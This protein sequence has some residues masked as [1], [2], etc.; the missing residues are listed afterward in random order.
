VT[1]NPSAE[2]PA[3]TPLLVTVVESQARRI[4]LGV[5][6]STD[7]SARAQA[8]YTDNNAFDR[9][10]NSTLKLEVDG[11]VQEAT[12]GLAFPRQ[13][14]GWR[15]LLGG[16]V[17][18]EDIQDQE[19]LNWSVSGAH[20]YAVEEY[21][22]ALSLQYLTERSRIGE[23]EW[24]NSEALFL[25]QRWLWNTLDDP[26]NPRVG[27]TFQLQVGGA[28]EALLSTRTFGRVHVRA[29]HL[30]YL[31]PQVSLQ[32]RGEA[33]AVLAD[34]RQGIPSEY[35]F[36]TGGDTSIRG[37]AFESLGVD[38]NGAVV[39]GRYLVVGSAELITWF[40]PQWG[41]AGFV[42]AGNAWDELD[43]FDPVY[44][45]GFGVRWRSPVGNLNLDLAWPEGRGEGRLH[46][47]VG[48]IFR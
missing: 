20:L 35:V 21:E 26:V 23:G 17:K 16:N 44:G 25:N 31:L 2:H 19:V 43:A 41:T 38:Q 12:A 28:S 3:D 48:I 10:W 45:V 15:Y 13:E 11:L 5:G 47:S 33:G 42:D 39:G 29:N 7:R 46:F 1:A 30:R 36:R 9:G 24:D 22:S 4:E 34:S 32:L 8:T 6:Y 27:S 14:S 37:F 40:S 18:H